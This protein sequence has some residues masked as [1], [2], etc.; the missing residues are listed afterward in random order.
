MKTNAIKLAALDLD[1]TLLDRTSKITPCTL[2]AI[3]TAIRRGV[4]VLPATGRGLSALP[5][6]VA[7]IP[8]VRYALTSNGAAV[9]DLGPDP[10]AAVRSRYGEP[11]PEP[12]AQP[13]CLYRRT[14]PAE[15][16]RAV[17]ALL[18]RYEGELNF[19]ADG[20]TFK[21]P[22]GLAWTRA[23]MARL[24]STEAKQ[25]D[26]GRFTILP[27]LHPYF[28]AHPGEIEKFCMFFGSKELASEVLPQ[29]AAIPGVEATQGSPD[30][31]EATAAG[32][33]KGTAL[34]ALAGQLGIPQA[35]VLAVGDSEN[36]RKMLE[37]AGVAAVMANGMLSIQS[38]ADIV[39]EQDCNHDG[40]AELFSRLGLTGL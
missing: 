8:G 23:R 15:T 16:A 7:S 6:V 38:L 3:V 2:E 20:R 22:A 4:V 5:R 32:V 10:M 35:E 36:D 14:L 18:E 29:L 34:L 30:N 25:V 31:V 17:Y 24:L 19:F 26:D 12:V 37:A 13:V 1:G 33:N 21:T 11:G 28:E 9:W 39:S 40:V 27:D